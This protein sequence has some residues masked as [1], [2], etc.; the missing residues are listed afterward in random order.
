[1]LQ[2]YKIKRDNSCNIRKITPALTSQ[3]AISSNNPQGTSNDVNL[4]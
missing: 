1:M 4:H 3:K 2:I